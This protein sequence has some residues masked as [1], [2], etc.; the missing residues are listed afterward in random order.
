MA[1][2]DGF[3]G[4]ANRPAHRCHSARPGHLTDPR[5]PRIA[6][7]PDGKQIG[8]IGDDGNAYVWDSA[9]G[10]LLLVLS[11]QGV[12]IRGIAY[13]QGGKLIATTSNGA[14]VKIW[15]GETGKLLNT[16]AGH[17][18]PTF[19]VAFSPDGRYLASTSVDGTVKI[20]N[21]ADNFTSQP[22][23]L[24]GHT[25]TIYRVAF[26]PDGTRLVTA[27]RDGTAR[28]YAFRVEELIALA[29]SRLTR[30]LTTEE[31]QKYLHVDACP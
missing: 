29:K 11:N 21:V 22:L 2:T 16:L 4:R 5:S 9:T 8:G 10:K 15:D 3:G 31:C 18:G 19:G 23:T 20:W 7:R 17:T 12:Q 6:Y 14:T 24:Y 30:E 1:G 26:S 28:V 25:G 13:S 27:S